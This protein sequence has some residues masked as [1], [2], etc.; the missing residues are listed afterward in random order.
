MTCLHLQMEVVCWL[1]PASQGDL[2]SGDPSWG[3][4]LGEEGTFWFHTPL[5]QETLRE[6]WRQLV[7]KGLWPR[8]CELMRRAVTWDEAAGPDIE[9]YGLLCLTCEQHW[10]LLLTLWREQMH[11]VQP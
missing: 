11:E 8:Y 4:D 6:A 9:L 1:W 2:V 3:I 5:P 10:E 7:Q